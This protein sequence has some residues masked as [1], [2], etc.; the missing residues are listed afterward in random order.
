[1][2]QILRSEEV[3]YLSAVFVVFTKIRDTRSTPL[4]F[5]IH[6]TVLR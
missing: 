3:K 4:Y 1:M 6:T 2:E 5:G